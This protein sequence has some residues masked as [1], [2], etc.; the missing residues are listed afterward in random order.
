MVRCGSVGSGDATQARRPGERDRVARRRGRCLERRQRAGWSVLRH[1]PA[2]ALWPRP[3][4]PLPIV[5]ARRHLLLSAIRAGHSAVFL[6]NLSCIMWLVATGMTG[7]RDRTVAVAL[8]VVAAESAVFVANRG[9][10]PVTPL[11][12]RLGAE[13]GTVSDIWLPEC[14]ARTLPVWSS[15]LLA[16]AAALHVRSFRRTAPAGRSAPSGS[17]SEPLTGSRGR[18]RPAR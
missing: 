8:A 12:E 4:E 11:A 17:G 2:L 3:A 13:R 1:R 10:C 5:S 9:V 15:A 18:R 14:A 16:L 7:R 6:V